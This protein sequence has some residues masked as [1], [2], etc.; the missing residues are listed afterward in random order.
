[1]I[2]DRLVLVG[3]QCLLG[4]EPEELVL[5]H[6]VGDE[7]VQHG[8]DA[9]PEELHDTSGGELGCIYSCQRNPESRTEVPDALRD[10]VILAIPKDYIYAC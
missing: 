4:T 1:M 7:D 3:L 9:L 5:R 2:V 10:H 6:E 8:V